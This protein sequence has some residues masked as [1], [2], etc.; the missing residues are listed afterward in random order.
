MI[1]SIAKPSKRFSSQV[2]IDITYV[3]LHFLLC[4][5]IA[6]SASQLYGVT[7]AD[8][9]G[10]V[11]FVS[12]NS[13]T[14]QTTFD[15]QFNVGAGNQV[16]AMTY[17][18]SSGRFIT[19]SRLISGNALG[20]IDSTA[21]SFSTVNIVGLPGTVPTISGIA[22]DMG[23][24]QL[25]VS[26]AEDGSNSEDR[27]A[28]LA[29]DGTVIAY[30]SDIANDIDALGFRS[31]TNQL[32][33]FDLNA[34][35]SQRVFDITGL[36]TSPNVSTIA[37]PP[38]NNDVG[39]VALDP[40]TGVIF[41]NGFDAA[42]GSLLRLD[43]DTTYFTVGDYGAIRQINGIAFMPLP[44]SV[45]P[46]IRMSYDVVCSSSIDRVRVLGEIESYD[47]EPLCAMVLSNGQHMFTCGSYLGRYDLTVPVDE[48]SQ[49]TVFGF[50]DGFCPYRDTVT[51]PECGP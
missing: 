25:L 20:F 48:N 36:F 37:T 33:G 9:F 16:G 51:A 47:G 19:A 31:T 21:Q 13:G 38:R 6:V 4:I 22:W 30:T 29:L 10:N 12:I 2:S 26:F 34:R 39:D 27:I 44:T 14:G 45:C 18:P 49:V 15:F 50:A 23:T 1:I 24:N 11:D 8:S 17:H 43:E 42:G 28:Q 40:D 32:L 41:A 7:A 5:P 46:L 35:N 3:L